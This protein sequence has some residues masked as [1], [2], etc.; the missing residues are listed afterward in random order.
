MQG[1]DRGVML[2]AALRIDRLAETRELEALE[3]AIPSLSDWDA[4][5]L[6]PLSEAETRWACLSQ[7]PIDAMTCRVRSRRARAKAD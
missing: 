2:S 1:L 5:T 3:R 4:S 7:K 6:Q